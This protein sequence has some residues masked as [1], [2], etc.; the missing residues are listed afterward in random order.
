MEL[1]WRFKN[2][3]TFNCYLRGAKVDSNSR[4]KQTAVDMLNMGEC[5]IDM[6]HRIYGK[7][8]FPAYPPVYPLFEPIIKSFF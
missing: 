2:K 7:L 4:I 6:E 1:D 8:E 3:L 5:F